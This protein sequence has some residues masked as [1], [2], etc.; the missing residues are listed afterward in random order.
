[1]KDVPTKQLGSA[2]ELSEFDILK[3]KR[4]Y[5]CTDKIGKYDNI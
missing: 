5:Q 1:M 3:L 4:M 2:T